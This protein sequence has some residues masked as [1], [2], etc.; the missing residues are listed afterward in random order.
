MLFRLYGILT[1]QSYFTWIKQFTW[2]YGNRRPEIIEEKL[3]RW[4]L[5]HFARECRVTPFIQNGST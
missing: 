4:R 3:V 5:S 2:F 1:G